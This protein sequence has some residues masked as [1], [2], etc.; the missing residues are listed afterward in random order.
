MATKRTKDG[1][2]WSEE[3]GLVQ[4]IPCEGAM[5]S[6][7]PKTTEFDVVVVGAGFAG[8]TAARDLAVRGQS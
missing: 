5:E 4:G 2:Q 8:V 3:T 6:T 7:P 1:Y